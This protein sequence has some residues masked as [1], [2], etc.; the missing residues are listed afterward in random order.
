[1]FGSNEHFVFIS[2]NFNN[3][4]HLTLIDSIYFSFITHSTLGYGDIS[5]KSSLMRCIVIIHI[6]FMITF[7]LL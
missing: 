7:L 6:L 3:V 1:M 2:S 5:V 4:K